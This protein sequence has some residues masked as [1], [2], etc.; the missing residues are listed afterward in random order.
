MDFDGNMVT[1]FSKTFYQITPWNKNGVVYAND[2]SR[3]LYKG[4]VNGDS[5][6][7]TQI[8]TVSGSQD[9]SYMGCGHLWAYSYGY[10]AS[11]SGYWAIIN[12]DTDV[13]TNVSISWVERTARCVSWADGKLY[14]HL[15]RDLGWG[16]LQKMWTSNEWDVGTSLSTSYVSYGWRF[17]KF[18]WNIVTWGMNT[19]NGTGN[20]Y[21]S[22]NYF[23]ATDGTLTLVQSNAWAYDSNI[24][25][26]KWFI[27]ENGY[28]YPFTSLGGSGVVLKTDKTFTDLDWKN[29]YLYR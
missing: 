18:L 6:T 16:K 14:R 26:D 25:G 27:D 20:G 1:T 19:N 13:V 24:E 4:V 8:G 7:F 28:I 3:K 21:W 29:P 15:I 5:I 11:S 12:P 23:I 10:S 2:G 22:N 17:G 9:I